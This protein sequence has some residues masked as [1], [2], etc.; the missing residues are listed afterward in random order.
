MFSSSNLFN[1]S[2]PINLR[3]IELSDIEIYLTFSPRFSRAID[4]TVSRPIY[5][6][7]T[8]SPRVRRAL[9]RQP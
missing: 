1:F 8:S 9:I 5:L 2:R 4:L 6:A 3:S 7:M